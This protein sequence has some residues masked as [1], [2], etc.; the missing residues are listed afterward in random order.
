MREMA[1]EL[2]G[3]IVLCIH[4]TVAPDDA[5]WQ[6]YVDAC[7]AAAALHAG[8]FAKVRQLVFTDGGGPNGAQRQRVVD[9]VDPLRNSKEGRVAVVSSSVAVRGIVT[10]FNWFNFSVRAFAPTKLGEAI[11]FLGITN[12]EA[13]RVRQAADR[14]CT[15]LNGGPPKSL[16]SLL[17]YSK[18]SPS[19]MQAR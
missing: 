13:E 12:T 9:A 5:G 18:P 14:M 19:L 10:V 16:T 7:L 8:D 15:T 6:T 3:D 1:C 11:G 17:A 2:V 4:T